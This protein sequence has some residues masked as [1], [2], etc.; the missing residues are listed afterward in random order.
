MDGDSISLHFA[1]T[2]WT[3]PLNDYHPEHNATLA[4]MFGPLVLAGLHLPSDVF[5]PLGG[6]ARA[7]RAAKPVSAPEATLPCPFPVPEAATNSM[8]MSM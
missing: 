3:A 4:F 5:V 8:S 7:R 6:T 2:L 1:P